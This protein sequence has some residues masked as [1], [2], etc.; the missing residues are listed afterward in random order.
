MKIVKFLLALIVAIGGVWLLDNSHNVKG[1]PV[2]ALGRVLNPFSGVW[3]NATSAFALAPSD[4]QM[5]QLNG[6]VE[7]KFDERMVP[8]IFAETTGD[9]LAVQGYLHARE[10]LFQMEFITR[11]VSGRLSEILGESTPTVNILRADRVMRRRGLVMGAENTLVALKKNTESYKLLER[12]VEGANAYIKALKPKDYPA[13]YKILG[14]TPEEWSPLKVALIMKYM[15]LD[16]CSG[17]NDLE[18]ANV[19]K[20]V[21]DFDFDKIYPQY[22]P[23][24]SPIVPT[25]TNW[26][27]DGSKVDYPSTSATTTAIQS[28]AD[29][30]IA[31]F[32]RGEDVF[33]KPDPGNGSNNWAVAASKTLNKKPILAGDPH[34]SLRLPSIWYENQLI[35]N[36]MNVYGASIPGVPFVVIGFNENIAWSPTNV[37]HDVTDWYSV[38]WV[39][40]KKESYLLDGKTQKVEYRI[41]KYNVKGKKDIVLDT[42]RMTH[43]GPVVYEDST[44]KKGMAYRWIAHTDP[45]GTDFSAF[46]KL[47]KA[48]NFDEYVTATSLFSNPAQNFAFISKAGDI[49]VRISGHLPMRKKG[50][51]RFVTDGSKSENGWTG[52]IPTE[53]VPMSHNPSRGFVSSANQHST[54]PSFPYYYHS[55]N[56]EQFRG[57]T[58]NRFLSKMDS[59]TP[60]D[61]KALQNN[62][63]SLF[64]EEALLEMIKNLDSTSLSAADKVAL[65]ELKAWNHYFDAD[66]T[67]PILFDIWYDK[68]YENIWDEILTLPNPK[69][70]LKPSQLAT[71]NLLRGKIDAKYFDVK[72]T[73]AVETAKN[74]VTDAFHKMMV[75]YVKERTLALAKGKAATFTWKDYKGTE[76]PHIMPALKGFGRQNIEN[77]GHR[78]ALNCNKKSH[79]PSWRMVVE[80][81][82]TPNAWVAYPGGQSGNIGSKYYDSF[83][84]T[85]AKGDYYQAI[86]LRK[87]DEQA[88]GI[89]SSQK[90]S[91]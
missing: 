13:E 76:I 67:A 12:Y 40:G 50:Q 24:Q 57:R 27:F 5:P 54:D 61:M 78:T 11:A 91:K 72:A 83:V 64:A 52:Y 1:A 73:P 31:G 79:G 68:M 56:F 86:F 70:F 21:G 65:E 51:G 15:A 2:P 26:G 60:D 25:G 39:D 89:V 22:F 7:V 42:I 44:M 47:N 46:H 28:G 66:K 8:H 17:E 84:D 82:E 10:R 71:I 55:E 3:Q 43:W 81:G 88:K 34:L 16:L 19:K 29:E 90:F 48:K 75:E 85:W 87:V 41:E 80:L 32:E 35:S 59:I 45:F 30:S 62:N 74:V 4:V 53:R 63:F 33:E 14:F 6:K 38:N 23:E 37:G 18:I 9:A 58:V 77:G 20:M 49:A 36:E 69:D